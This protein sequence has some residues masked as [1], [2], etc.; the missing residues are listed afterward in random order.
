MN[1]PDLRLCVITFR[2]PE[3]QGGH[4]LVSRFIKILEPLSDKIFVI[5]G[6]FPKNEIL[7]EKICIR[8]VKHGKKKSI[9][10]K[11]C[12]YL[13]YQ[14]K[15]A[16]ELVKIRKDA[17][18]IIFYIGTTLL[19]P[20]LTAKLLR[21]KIV[22]IATGSS[23]KGAEIQFEGKT[24]GKINLFITK[25]S[26]EINHILSDVIIVYTE[27]LIQWLGL[28]KH[29]NKISIAY[30]HFLDFN[31]FKIKKGLD[32]RD[33]L[34]GY[35]G[36]LSEEK[37][38]LNFFKAIP[39]I[40]KER[41]MIKFLIVGDGQLRDTIE[42]YLDEENLNDKIKLPGWIPHN[43]LPDYLNEL[44]LVVLPSYTEGLPNIMLE[45]MACGTPVLAT[46]VGAIP[47]VIKDGETG[48]IMGN[49][50]PG[51]IAENVERVLN[52][53]ALD[54]IIKNAKELVEKEFTYEAAVGRYREILRS[55]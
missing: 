7:N 13:L 5:T 52:H 33:N 22:T 35:I 18:I 40:T 46:P 43:K 14:I 17:D 36:R 44:K 25:L 55:I 1:K 51:C 4:V 6:N 29:R 9:L 12:V 48:F 50:S 31:E 34:V 47:D 8:N 21:K 39:E 24:F 11:M 49:N 15:E 2:L 53:P 3:M 42:R 37:G 38:I 27:N 32:E 10:A 41:S 20:L 19:I 26:E 16:Y 30:E 23:S 45:A 28:E 54:E